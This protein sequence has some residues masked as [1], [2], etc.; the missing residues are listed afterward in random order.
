MDETDGVVKELLSEIVSDDDQTDDLIEFLKARKE[1][2]A[3]MKGRC[4]GKDCGNPVIPGE[5]H[6]ERCALDRLVCVN[7]GDKSSEFLCRLCIADG[8]KHCVYCLRPRL[9]TGALCAHDRNA[10]G[11]EA[12]VPELVGKPVSYASPS[13][14]AMEENLSYR[15][16]CEI[17]DNPNRPGPV[18]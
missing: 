8:H 5:D 3:A 6:C 16:Q 4:R 11:K 9:P 10:L 7:C 15:Q 18:A 13:E 1:K 17:N 2:R 12:R 14:I